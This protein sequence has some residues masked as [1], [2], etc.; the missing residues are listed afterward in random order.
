MVSLMSANSMVFSHDS[1][2]T[3][4]QMSFQCWAM[5]HTETVGM[6]QY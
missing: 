6:I 4:L 1:L 5:L 3:Y 2:N